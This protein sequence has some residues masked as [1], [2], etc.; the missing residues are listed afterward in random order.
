MLVFA[1]IKPD[2]GLPRNGDG[3]II[4]PDVVLSSG[5]FLEDVIVMAGEEP[6][7]VA[8]IVSFTNMVTLRPGG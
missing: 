1:I 5:K 2:C 3:I 8:G 6:L 7:I 4:N